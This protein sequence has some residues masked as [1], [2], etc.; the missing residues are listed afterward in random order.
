MLSKSLIQFS[1]DGQGCV[2]SWLFD[3]RPDYGGG[4]EDNGTS[5]KKSYGCTAAPSAPTFLDSAGDSS[6]L[7]G[8][9]GSVSFVITAPFFWVLV[10][11]RF[12]LCPPRVCF[13][14][15]V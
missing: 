14:S 12:C 13:P 10:C 6:T 4:S 2:P 15:P 5:F 9:F 7:M 3:L 1:V 11:I 8:K